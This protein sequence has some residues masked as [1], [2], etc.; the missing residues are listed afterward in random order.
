MTPEERLVPHALRF[1]ALP[2]VQRARKRLRRIQLRFE[3]M[4]I[5]FG[6]WLLH[7]GERKER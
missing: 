5:R 1:L 2:W 3:T 4:Q 7:F 6:L